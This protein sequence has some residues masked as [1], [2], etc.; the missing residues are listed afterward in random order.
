MCVRPA[1]NPWRTGLTLLRLAERRFC[2]LLF[3]EPPRTT[4]REQLP[5]VQA[6]P[7]FGAPV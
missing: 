3:Q 2:G 4:R 6:E 5:L 7:F 1:L